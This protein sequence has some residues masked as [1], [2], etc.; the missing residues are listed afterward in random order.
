MAQRVVGRNQPSPFKLTLERL[1][2]VEKLLKK[3][4]SSN[5]DSVRK[6]FLF[7][8]QDHDGFITSEDFIRNFSDLDQHYKDINKLMKERDQNSKG[9]INYQDFSTWFG[10]S[11]HQSAGFYFRHDSKR[12]PQYE[13]NLLKKNQ[14]EQHLKKVSEEIPLESLK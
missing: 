8:D 9:K 13:K 2:M 12:N 10:N 3:K 11:I 7:M 1:D 14:K 5:F 6:A 4:F